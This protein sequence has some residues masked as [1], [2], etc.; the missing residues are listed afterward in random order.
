M[1]PEPLAELQ[2]SRHAT[3]AQADRLEVRYESAFEPPSG[4]SMHAL[5]WRL[6]ISALESGFVW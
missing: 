6:V 1:Q 2:H 4:D 3:S 5:V